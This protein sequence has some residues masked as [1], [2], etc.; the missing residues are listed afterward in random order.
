MTPPAQAQKGQQTTAAQS[1][2]VV[3]AAATVA[4]VVELRDVQMQGLTVERLASVDDI[5]S[6]EGQL[7]FTPKHPS[8]RFLPASSTI[9]VL[10]GVVVDVLTQESS[11]A[12]KHLKSVRQ[13]TLAR[14]AVD[15]ELSYVLTVPPPPEDVRE[16]YFRCFSEV[17]GTYNAWPYLRE[18]VQD[19]SARMGLPPI[20]LPVYRVPRPKSPDGPWSS[21][22]PS[23]ATPETNRVR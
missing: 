5:L 2:D 20:T 15:Y 13:R 23:P 7:K 10:V 12:Q 3:G 9:E 18:A 21:P 19:I 17:N 8:F 6:V 14:I 1:V 22:Q 16:M 4:R 11:A